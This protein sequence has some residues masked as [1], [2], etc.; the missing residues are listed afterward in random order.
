MKS[1]DIAVAGRRSVM[2]K[3]D[4]ESLLELITRKKDDQAV[5]ISDIDN[6]ESFAS[7]IVS[8]CN[9]G[10]GKIT[11]ERKRW[12]KKE[13]C[14]STS[15]LPALTFSLYF[16]FTT[17]GYV[18]ADNEIPP[19]TTLTLSFVGDIMAHDVIL[20]RPPYSNI[21]THVESFLKTDDLSF[22]NLEF[23]VDQEKSPSGYPLFNVHKD[24]VE[25]SVAAGFEVFSL[26]NNHV[27]DQG[28]SSVKNSVKTITQI[29]H[30]FFSGIREDSSSL[31]RPTLIEKKGWRIGFIAITSFSNNKTETDHLNLVNYRDPQIRENFISAMADYAQGYDLFIIS[32]H[33][34]IE[35][36]PRA[37]ELKMQ[38]FRDLIKSGTDI[39]WGH[40][41]HVVQPWESIHLEERDA[42]ILASCGNFI[43][44]Q[45]WFMKTDKPGS[46]APT[47]DSAIFQVLV[48]KE[49]ELSSIKSV[50]PVYISN[51][52]DPQKGMIVDLTER[53]INSE[54]ISE[55]WR[56]YY[57]KR[58]SIIKN[59]L[60]Q[61]V[62]D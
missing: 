55:N 13:K 10:G 16:F 44:G 40:H 30:I 5:Y 14:L 42:L 1:I 38:F 4:N 29:P 27:A 15:I 39:I 35:Y 43:S 51:Y 12:L 18:S 53:L 58:F 37:N 21:Y 23:P 56:L 31:M 59:H 52:R 17:G 24:F 50:T 41:P 20:N 33:D 25:A 26:A 8:F 2:N 34:G 49:D 54:E 46:R 9:S 60:E 45:T 47:G 11:G 36:A 28:D 3:M 62:T 57:K 7:E 61:N 22:G 32:V 19:A 48:K 6:E